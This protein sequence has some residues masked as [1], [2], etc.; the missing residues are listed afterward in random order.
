MS[1][2]EP[3]GDPYRSCHPAHRAEAPRVSRQETFKGFLKKCVRFSLKK[4]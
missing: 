1:L 3:A 2:G 4:R